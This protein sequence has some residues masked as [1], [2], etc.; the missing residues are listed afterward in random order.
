MYDSVYLL[1]KCSRTRNWLPGVGIA[2]F[3]IAATVLSLCV[4]TFQNQNISLV[5]LYDVM[6]IKIIWLDWNCLV[7]SSALMFMRD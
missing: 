3:V 7:I 1:Q 5:L 6:F 2:V 4:S